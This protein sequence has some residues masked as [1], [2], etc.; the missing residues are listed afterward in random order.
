MFLL[1]LSHAAGGSPYSAAFLMRASS[2]AVTL[3]VFASARA[4][5]GTGS[6]GNGPRPGS[7]PDQAPRRHR[8]LAWMLLPAA[9]IADAAAE[10]CFAAASSYGELSI[11]AVL[12]A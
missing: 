12:S 10:A 11:A 5:N 6:S 4:G 8:S 3:T 9:G 7:A 2:C 1:L